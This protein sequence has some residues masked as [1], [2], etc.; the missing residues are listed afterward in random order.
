MNPQTNSFLIEHFKSEQRKKLLKV[1]T[2]A[3]EPSNSFSS[4]AQWACDLRQRANSDAPLSKFEMSFLIR[5]LVSTERHSTSPRFY[6]LD[7]AQRRKSLKEN[8]IEQSKFKAFVIRNKTL[9]ASA[10]VSHFKEKMDTEG[11]E[12]NFNGHKTNFDN[13]NK[14]AKVGSNF[15]IQTP[16][17][18]ESSPNEN[19]QR[20]N[21]FSEQ[22]AQEK[23][24]ANVEGQIIGNLATSKSQEVLKDENASNDENDTS[25]SKD[26]SAEDDTE[27]VDTQSLLPQNS[28]NEQKSSKK[29]FIF[30]QK[31]PT[32]PFTLKEFPDE[33]SPL[34]Y[35]PQNS[36]NYSDFISYLRKAGLV[37]PALNIYHFSTEDGAYFNSFSV[38]LENK[39]F[40]HKVA[41]LPLGASYFLMSCPKVVQ[42][43]FAH[44]LALYYLEG[45]KPIPTHV[46]FK[47]FDKVLAKLNGEVD[48]Q[49]NHSIVSRLRS[50]R[51]SNF[52]NVKNNYIFGDQE[53]EFEER[54]ASETSSYDES[55]LNQIKKLTARESIYDNMEFRQSLLKASNASIKEDPKED[56]D[57]DLSDSDDSS[58]SGSEDSFEENE[59]HTTNLFELQY[60]KLKH[61]FQTYDLNI[62]PA[63]FLLP[64][65]KVQVLSSD[66]VYELISDFNNFSG[67]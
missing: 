65:A 30:N 51:K 63:F 43:C 36:S 1:S 9:V 45:K 46:T 42:S 12:K 38:H 44:E 14:F 61:K 55:S 19:L 50:H 52:F 49:L 62:A 23:T 20:E 56:V 5:S 3:Q 48:L 6:D 29:H 26:D 58:R 31:V 28:K 4:Q 16:N 34:D 21:G 25:N 15:P 11:S 8:E 66:E 2:K 22:I 10:K 47:D 39:N 7:G 67:L 13:L 64:T 24:A 53:G 27:T 37:N 41:Y 54:L 17:Q 18:G 40:G 32:L 35:F 33:V 60:S 59:Y 57:V